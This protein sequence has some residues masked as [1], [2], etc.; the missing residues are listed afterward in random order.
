MPDETPP[1]PTDKEIKAR[2]DR[3]KENLDP[4]EFIDADSKLEEI[5]SRSEPT[6]IPKSE[7]D[8]YEQKLNLLDEKMRVAKAA[9][10]KATGKVE[11]ASLSGSFDRGTA[12]GMG[13]GLT[14]AYTI[15][16]MPIAGFFLGKLLNNLTGK[17]GFHIWL[18]IFGGIIGI[19]WVSMVA[20]RN[21]NRF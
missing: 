15:V 10:A 5:L 8:E 13:F 19:W 17:E 6:K 18:T 20:T 12:V 7:I 11:D 2:F 3:I 21:A 9:K 14:L 16:G 4:G 1:L